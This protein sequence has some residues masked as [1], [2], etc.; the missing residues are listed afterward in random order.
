V[1]Q[2][3]L[4]E[5]VQHVKPI[6]GTEKDKGGPSYT[7]VFSEASQVRKL[8]TTQEIEAL[9][10]SW[11]IIQHKIGPYSGVLQNEDDLSA[12]IR[13]LAEGGTA[14]PL[15][16]R[17]SLQLVELCS[18]VIQRAYCL[19]ASLESH[20]E[21]LPP[22]LKSDLAKYNIGT[23]YYSGRRVISTETGLNFAP[24]DEELDY[25]SSELRGDALDPNQLGVS[26]AEL[27]AM[28]DVYASE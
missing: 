24:S 25:D 6:Q 17:N 3:T 20:F 14:F 18:S 26:E 7:R 22:S 8:L 23:S 27:K 9:Y 2:W 19:S 4:V 11:D 12:W 21:S 28:K 16:S 15:A 5:V 10:T 13:R 1:A